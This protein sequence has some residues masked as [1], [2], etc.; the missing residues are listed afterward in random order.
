MNLYPPRPAGDGR[1]DRLQAWLAFAIATALFAALHAHQD[2]RVFW[3]D[4]G[5]YWQLAD[6]P[7]FTRVPNNIRGYFLAVVL[8]PARYLSD[9]TVSFWPLRLFLSAAY[10]WALT[11]LVPLAY[12]ALFGGRLS[13]ARRLVPAVLMIAIFPGLLV[14]PMSDLPALLLMVGSL[15]A[16]CR[17]S[18]GPAGTL[19]L[20]WIA[21]AGALAAAAYNVRTIYL[22]L[23]VGALLALAFIGRRAAWRR[24]LAAGCVFAAAAFAVLLPQGLINQHIH[25]RFTFNPVIMGNGQ[26][27]FVAQLVQGLGVQRYETMSPP[28]PGAGAVRYADPA[29]ARL[30]GEAGGAS[31]IQSPWDYVAKVVLARPLDFAGLL[32]RH[33][34]NGLDVRDG[35]VYVRRY[36]SGRGGIAAANFLVLAACAWVGLLLLA[37]RAAAGEP[38]PAPAPHWRLW[39]LLW[40]AP[41]GFILPGMI[42]T[43]FF[44]PLH[45]LA[46]CTLAFHGQP[47]ALAASLRSHPVLVPAALLAAAGLFFGVTLATMAQGPA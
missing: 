3:F 40:L 24:Q 33:V 22:F 16:L 18:A 43:R 38:P 27:L 47:H 7:G 44:V 13:L 21:L 39:L 6:L 5:F 41:V 11:G 35:T 30:L 45:L 28:L 46:W 23:L 1:P 37:R 32:G 34:V 20:G 36:S 19:A 17:A 14:N 26:S 8:A 4:A 2:V 42:E 15:L 31:A 9:L 12:T 29:G 25:G 10:A